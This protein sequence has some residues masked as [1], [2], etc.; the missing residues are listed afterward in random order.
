MAGRRNARAS[1]RGDSASAAES[2]GAFSLFGVWSGTVV[3]VVDLRWRGS[4]RKIG[5]PTSCPCKRDAPQPIEFCYG[6]PP[7]TWQGMWDAGH[8]P[9]CAPGACRSGTGRGADGRQSHAASSRSINS[10]TCRPLVTRVCGSSGGATL[11]LAP[12][13]AKQRRS[14]EER[15]AKRGGG[16]RTVA[17]ARA[18]AGGCA[19]TPPA[20]VGCGPTGSA[21]SRRRRGR[22]S[23]PTRRRPNGGGG[24]ACPIGGGPDAGARGVLSFFF[25]RL[26]RARAAPRAGARPQERRARAWLGAGAAPRGRRPRVGGGGGDGGGGGPAAKKRRRRSKLPPPVAA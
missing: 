5:K 15:K 8:Q 6:G 4:C 2:H 16:R 23:Y 22:R 19:S 9:Q 18:G 17:A 26:G 7:Q 3:A 1:A 11:C 10:V 12:M 13:G 21:P 14:G 25:S 24:G 20:A